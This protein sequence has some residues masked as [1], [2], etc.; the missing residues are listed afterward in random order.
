MREREVLTDPLTCDDDG[1]LL[2]F[3]RLLSTSLFVVLRLLHRVVCAF[4][5]G[6]HSGSGGGLVP[7]VYDSVLLLSGQSQ[8]IMTASDFRRLLV[9]VVQQGEKSPVQ[10]LARVRL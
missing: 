5:F 6:V 3:L 2:P 4:W 10:W 1:A 7:T 8:F 9:L